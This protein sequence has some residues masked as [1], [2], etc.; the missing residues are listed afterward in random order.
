MSCRL[1]S[2][3][4]SQL[5]SRPALVIAAAERRLIEPRLELLMLDRHADLEP[6][7]DQE[8]THRRVGHRHVAIGELE[9]EV[10]HARLGQQLLGL[11]AR[12]GD[13]AGEARHLDEPPPSLAASF[14][15]RTQRTTDTA[16][17]GDLRE[18]GRAL[19][20][21]DCQRKGAT[22]AAR[23]RRAS[24]PLLKY[25]RRDCRSMAL[26]RQRPWRPWPRP[27][28]RARRRLAAE[29]GHHPPALDG[30]DDRGPTHEYGAVSVEIGLG[31]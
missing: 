21:I 14:I 4:K 1:G 26:R 24:F 12:G 15:A 17:D 22:H 13:V 3:M 20:A 27:A 8:H 30:V 31:P 10:G 9:L 5:K 25:R 16:H 18:R 2:S 29:L 11:G 23:R 7:D 28:C 6:L 19:P